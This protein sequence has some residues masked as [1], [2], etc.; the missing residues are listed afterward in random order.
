[1]TLI[2]KLGENIRAARYG[3]VLV[4]TIFDPFFKISLRNIARKRSSGK[5]MMPATNEK[6]KKEDIR[7]RT[8]ARRDFFAR[9]SSFAAVL[10]R[11]YRT[12]FS[13][14]HHGPISIKARHPLAVAFDRYA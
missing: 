10:S 8:E 4:S 14:R 2:H 6:R 12:K 5:K 3:R 7:G 11:Y 1:M 9:S 13:C